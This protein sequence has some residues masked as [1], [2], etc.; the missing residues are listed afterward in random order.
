M[1]IQ[2]LATSIIIDHPKESNSNKRVWIRELGAVYTYKVKL[3]LIKTK[4]LF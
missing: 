2:P 3:K 4:L 1:F